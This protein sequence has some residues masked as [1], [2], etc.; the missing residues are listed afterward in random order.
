METKWQAMACGNYVIP[1]FPKVDLNVRPIIDQLPMGI[2]FVFTTTPMKDLMSD[3]HTVFSGNSSYFCLNPYTTCGRH[4]EG[5]IRVHL[6]RPCALAWH[7]KNT[8]AGIVKDK[9]VPNCSLIHWGPDRNIHGCIL[10]PFLDDN[11]KE[12][13]DLIYAMMPWTKTHSLVYLTGGPFGD[14]VMAPENYKASE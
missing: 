14:Q 1:Y 7:A 2:Y 3:V 9:N 5:D 8:I 4:I 6:Q 12:C 11:E 10:G 13:L